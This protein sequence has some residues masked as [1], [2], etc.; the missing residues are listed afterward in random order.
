MQAHDT[1]MSKI[2]KIRRT[3]RNTVRGTH[4]FGAPTDEELSSLT[5]LSLS[6][7]AM[8]YAEP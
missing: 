5:S 2:P 8:G 7:S 3:K 4:I 6:L 1:Y